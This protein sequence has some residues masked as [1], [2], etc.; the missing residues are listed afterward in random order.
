[1][2]LLSC[3][4]RQLEAL[5]DGDTRI[6]YQFASRANRM[7]T[8]APN[9]Y[10]WEAFDRMIRKHFSP[11]LAATDYR[12]LN[13][14]KHAR[15]RVVVILYAGKEATQA[16]L[17]KLTRQS[18][19]DRHHSLGKG[20]VFAAKRPWRTDAVVPLRKKDLASWCH[21]A[22]NQRQLAF[23]TKCFG[24]SAL[25]PSISHSFGADR[26][27]NI[28]CELGKTSKEYSDSNGNP[29]GKASTAIDRDGDLST[30]TWSTCLGSNVC[31]VLGGMHGDTRA[32]FA[33]S[34]DLTRL[35][36]WIP[37]GSADCEAYAAQLLDTHP[38]GTPGLRTRGDPERCLKSH[39][40]DIE[41]Q[42]LTTHA[43]I[44]RFIA[45][46]KVANRRSGVCVLMGS[47]S[48]KGT[49]YFIEQTANQVRV[50]GRLSGLDPGYHGLH[51][52]ETGD[53]TKGCDSAGAHLNP[54]GAR[55]GDRASS[56]RHVGDLGNI[57]AN[58][59]GD[60]H[61][62]FMDDVIS[63]RGVRR[64]IIGRMLVVHAGRDDGGRARTTESMSSGTAGHRVS[65]G[66]IGRC[67]YELP[68]SFS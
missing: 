42:L 24:K 10:N 44:D 20:R 26:T 36:L 48:I 6:A 63:L 43:E 5:L 62:D 32:R 29:I 1:M 3:V 31:G 58:S 49:V 61:F 66:I 8:A 67:K 53:M 60:S 2:G 37:P 25:H 11:M 16:Y 54:Y 41:Q 21:Q 22:D 55:H 39:S 18:I 13:L 7:Q 12:L 19:D 50:V 51:V 17:F 52:H 30:S 9:G 45:T 4:R 34:P 38:H 46:G 35:A 59:N 47:K 23:R 15:G 33:V 40:R 68:D 27:H 56:V 14:H 64:N 57:K 28:C 65:C